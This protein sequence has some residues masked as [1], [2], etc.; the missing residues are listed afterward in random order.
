MRLETKEQ[1]KAARSAWI[2]GNTTETYKDIEI[3]TTEKDYSGRIRYFLTIWRG[4]AG[5]PY[6]NYCYATS[7]QRQERIESEK[8]SANR[9]EEYRIQEKTKGR[10]LTQSALAAKKIKEI[11]KKEYANLDFSVRSRNFANGSS[12]DIDWIDGVPTK[13]I[14][15]FANQFQYGH[16]D[17]MTD[18]YEY[19]NSREFP[20]AKFV[21]CHRSI[22]KEKQETIREQLAK[23]MDI[24]NADYAVIPKEFLVN[25]RGYAFEAPLSALVYQIAIDFDFSKGFHGVRNK[26]TETGEEISNMFE[27]Y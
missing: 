12:V 14:E 18:C 8:M 1:R 5:N 11:L 6:I 13:E 20:Q 7:E 26:R 15:S 3:L 27:L 25:V 2:S 22:S 4:Q 9:R 10:T 19:S 21:M 23:K 17:G 16:F 24:E